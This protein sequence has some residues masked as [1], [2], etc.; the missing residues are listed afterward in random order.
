[1]ASLPAIEHIEVHCSTPAGNVL[2]RRLNRGIVSSSVVLSD[3]GT[4][5][6]EL[7]RGAMVE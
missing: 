3:N 4:P 2:L 7:L 6:D 1:M 5:T